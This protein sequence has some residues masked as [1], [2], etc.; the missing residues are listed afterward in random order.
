[1]ET[2]AKVQLMIR[3]LSGRKENEAGGLYRK[4]F[5][6]HTVYLSPHTH[7]LLLLDNLMIERRPFNLTT[8]RR[9]EYTQSKPS[10]KHARGSRNMHAK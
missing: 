10:N 8:V 3:F 6:K 9:G 2:L 5:S 1:M 4:N 7:V